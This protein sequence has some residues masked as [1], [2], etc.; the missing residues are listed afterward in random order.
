MDA[1]FNVDP[2]EFHERKRRRIA[3]MNTNP[4]PAPKMAPTSAPGVH[5]IAGFLPGR[6]EF[7]HEVENEAED[8]VK[9][10]EFGVCLEWGGGEIPEDENDM[11]VKGRARMLEE[12]KMRESTPGKRL[13]N[14]LS[15]G[16]INGFHFLSQLPKAESPPKNDKSDE[17]KD[18][19]VDEDAEEP[20]QPPPI[21]TKESLT[22]KLTLLEMYRQRVEK[23]QEAKALI[24]E[25][26]LLHYKQV[27][28][29]AR[30]A[31]S[32]FAHITTDAS[33]RKEA[34]EGGKGHRTSSAPVRSDTDRRRLR[35]FRSRHHLYASNCRHPHS[36]ANCLT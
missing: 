30:E 25:R 12:A 15:N 20:T 27:C 16:V 2:E 36:S 7:E 24:F 22:F 28:L 9:D 14:G 1:H 5:E 11:D 21:E 10:L 33:K 8:V 23:R 17:N 34:S 18:E 26:G 6:L 3:S 35:I 4:P 32:C 19:N 31:E 29:P 13:P